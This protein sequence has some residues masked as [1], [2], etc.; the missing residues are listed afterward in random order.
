MSARRSSLE[1]LLARA[2]KPSEEAMRLHP[3]YRGKMQTLPKCPI[4]SFDDFA[5]WYSP[6]VAAPCR[7]IQA[8]PK[9]VFFIER[10]GRKQRLASDDRQ[11]WREGPSFQQAIEDVA[12]VPGTGQ[13]DAPSGRIVVS[14]V[15][16]PSADRGERRGHPV[17]ASHAPR[18]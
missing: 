12:L 1:E 16:A 14:L 10:A 11:R 3:V 13:R 2:R 17:G 4:R 6:G 7:A 15:S 8:E 18:G 9:L 5:I